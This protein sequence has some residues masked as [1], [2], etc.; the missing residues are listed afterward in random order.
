MS[1]LADISERGCVGSPLLHE[2]TES[3][4]FG[5]AIL[6]NTWSAVTVPHRRYLRC[7]RSSKVRKVDKT[8]VEV[9]RRSSHLLAVLWVALLRE[10][11]RVL[12]RRLLE[13]V[14]SHHVGV[15]ENERVELPRLLDWLAGRL[16]IL[17]HIDRHVHA[18]EHVG[19][20]RQRWHAHHW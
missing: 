13:V 6:S 18:I 4:L 10:A 2:A 12:G 20:G 5:L 19:L 3:I 8:P 11:H 17:V 16:P 15:S 1:K 7:R 9:V 14:A